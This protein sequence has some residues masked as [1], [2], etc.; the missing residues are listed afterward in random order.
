M[1]RHP[2]AREAREGFGRSSVGAGL[3]APRLCLVE[4]R[5]SASGPNRLKETIVSAVSFV[6]PNVLGLGG[7]GIDLAP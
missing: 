4:G 6:G 3:F 2:G 7:A 1:D 5:G